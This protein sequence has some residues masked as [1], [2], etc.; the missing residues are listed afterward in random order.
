M[1]CNVRTAGLSRRTVQGAAVGTRQFKVQWEQD[2][3]AR[4]GNRS[5]PFGVP[6]GRAAVTRSYASDYLSD[7]CRRGA[8]GQAGRLSRR[9]RS[10]CQRFSRPEAQRRLRSTPQL[11]SLFTRFQIETARIGVGLR[12]Q[13]AMLPEAASS[14]ITRSAGVIDINSA[15]GQ[16]GG[17]IETTPHNN[18]LGGRDERA[19]QL[20]HAVTSAASSSRLHRHG[21]PPRT[22]AT[23][24]TGCAT[25]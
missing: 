17:D 6:R 7:G 21:S 24:R 4:Q 5:G 3:E 13:G 14:S 19:R 18:N 10:T 11:N 15:R 16:R 1:G 25:R 9:P 23:S 12:S 22:N 8:G 20:T 2:T